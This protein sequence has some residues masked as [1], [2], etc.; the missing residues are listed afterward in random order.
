MR[1]DAIPNLAPALC[2]RHSNRIDGLGDRAN[3]RG[4]PGCPAKTF[5]IGQHDV[6][7]AADVVVLVEK[8][9]AVCALAV[10]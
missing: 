9:A 6:G 1:L 5:E 7:I 8:Q 10:E 4:C 3:H 2:H